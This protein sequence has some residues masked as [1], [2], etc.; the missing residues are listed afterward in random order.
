MEQQINY[1]PWHPKIA[2]SDIPH[3]QNVSVTA[4]VSV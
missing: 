1:F 4:I 3:I 2:A